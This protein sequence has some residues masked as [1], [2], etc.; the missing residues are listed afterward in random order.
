M[1]SH[2]VQT[3]HSTCSSAVSKWTFLRTRA[4]TTLRV[5]RRKFQARIL[6]PPRNNSRLVV[7]TALWGSGNQ[8]QPWDKVR[9][10]KESVFTTTPSSPQHTPTLLLPPPSTQ[11]NTQVT[12]RRQAFLNFIQH[13][14]PTIVNKIDIPAPVIQAMRQTITSML[15][16]LP[17]SFFNITISAKTEN[18]AQ[19][20]LSVLMTGYMFRS[21]W[22]RMGLS[23]SLESISLS[24][25]M[26]TPMN[27]HHH[28]H[29]H[30]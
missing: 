22:T 8:E 12:D 23:R 25:M 18:F 4:C 10:L 28:H 26:M 20:M 21:A 17:P 11:H 27:Y 3:R 16:T 7:V 29:H 2:R 9:R 30:W 14:D 1:Y 5:R 24:L 15:G 6:N 13:A 19:L